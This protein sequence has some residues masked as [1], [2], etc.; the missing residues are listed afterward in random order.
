MSDQLVLSID[1]E[2]STDFRT[3]VLRPLWNPY[4]PKCNVPNC[5]F[6]PSTFRQY[7]NHWSKIHLEYIT[8]HK[9]E[10]CDRSFRK[11]MHAKRHLIYIH[12]RAKPGPLIK[13]DFVKNAAYRD[14]YHT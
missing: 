5:N 2:E 10:L 7:L 12:Q 1:D 3:H 8:I 9:C 4:E 13:K 14:T 11:Y 6:R